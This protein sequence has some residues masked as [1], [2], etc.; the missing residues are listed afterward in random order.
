M[1]ENL[2]QVSAYD[3]PEEEVK[4]DQ[5]AVQPQR[6]P[7]FHARHGLVAFIRGQ[8]DLQAGL[9][10]LW[11]TPMNAIEQRLL[12]LCIGR[13][14][15]IEVFVEVSKVFHHL[16]CCMSRSLLINELI[17]PFIRL[18]MALE[19]KE[20]FCW[21]FIFVIKFFLRADLSSYDEFIVYSS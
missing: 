11:Q 10:L 9:D 2:D 1:V 4:L 19:V 20:I 14:I 15:G 13:L 3:L 18:T 6:P 5:E 8:R 12:C 21:F 7:L 16:L 17:C